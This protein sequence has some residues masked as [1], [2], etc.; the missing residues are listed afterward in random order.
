MNKSVS[1]I[2]IILSSFLL[3]LNINL[4]NVIKFKKETIKIIPINNNAKNKEVWL[5]GI[6]IDR[7][8]INL[9]KFANQDWQYKLNS[10]VNY[11]NNN[12]LE[13]NL[14]YNKSY[15]LIF[16]KSK[17]SGKTKIIIDKKAPI[18]LDLHSDQFSFSNIYIDK[19]SNKNSF[20]YHLIEFLFN[21]FVF[22]IFTKLINNQIIKLKTFKKLKNSFEDRNRFS[23][24]SFNIVFLIIFAFSL[25]YL[26]SY[27][28]GIYSIDSFDQI[29]Q[30]KYN[31]ITDNHPAFF[32][33]ILSIFIK[34][35]KH[36][37]SF[38]ISQIVFFAIIF[39]FL[40]NTLTNNIKG[41]L[42]LLILLLLNPVNF[43]MIITLWKDIYY[44]LFLFLFGLLIYYDLISKKRE[45]KISFFIYLTGL[46]TTLTRHNGILT[47]IVFFIFLFAYLILSSVKNKYFQLKKYFL[48]FLLIIISFFLY[49]KF[50]IKLIVKNSSQ[51]F[52]YY[53]NS[54]SL[55]NQFNYLFLY[56]SL[57][58]IEKMKTN[59]PFYEKINKI[60]PIKKTSE[61]PGFPYYADSFFR[62]KEVD[63]EKLYHSNFVFPFFMKNLIN[64]P[65]EA[66]KVFLKNHSLIWKF[67][68]YPDAYTYIPT[69]GIPKWNKN[70]CE[71]DCYLVT[72]SKLPFLKK[73]LDRIYHLILDNDSLFVFFWRPGFH[74]AVSLI[75][76][77][78]IISIR[79]DTIL[80][81]PFLTTLANL[82]PYLIILFPQDFRYL[83]INLLVFYFYFY[84]L[85]SIFLLA[86][87]KI[88]SN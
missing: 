75:F 23:F 11:K 54:F 80:L 56:Y 59:D 8:R 72:K 50:L 61:I 60:M 87:K 43:F 21:F 88:K 7:Q 12:P 47:L 78:I 41:K 36:P 42:G 58:Y 77:I 53:N 44:S 19:N 73:I 67:Y 27:W 5:I 32:T 30:A 39:S 40:I 83:Y 38:I 69:N 31:L 33:Y 84:Y 15:N 14:R 48:I 6:E 81:I 17:W 64:E 71:A 85:I 65:K 28:P 70:E 26:F 51:I 4:F 68:P 20:Y 55:I 3:A 49:K 9:K 86:G 22:F 10:L 79:N 76:L 13:L 57:P 16:L 45:I 63:K 25:I 18:I 2:L 66:I 29:K 24:I 62:L 52:A 35:F 34:L 82:I 37:V 46:L 1:N 74:L